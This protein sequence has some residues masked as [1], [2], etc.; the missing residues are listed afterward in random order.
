MEQRNSRR[1]SPGNTSR[2]RACNACTSFAHS[3]HL[4]QSERRTSDN[5]LSGRC[6][7]AA[8]SRDHPF[9]ASSPRTLSLDATGNQLI[10]LKIV[11][12]HTNPIILPA[13][14]SLS[15]TRGY[16]LG[17]TLPVAAKAIAMT[18]VESQTAMTLACQPAP[19]SKLFR[20]YDWGTRDGSYPI[21]LLLNKQRFR[22]KAVQLSSN[23]IKQTSVQSITMV[24]SDKARHCQLRDFRQRDNPLCIAEG[25]GAGELVGA[26]S[27]LKLD[28]S[29]HALK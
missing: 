27:N 11:Q 24:L 22:W 1:D 3:L 28:V 6:R 10:Q 8:L 13:S 2:K 17:T 21:P 23:I 7:T 15:K 16:M 29:L 4:S 26:F 18:V 25:V 12:F 20:N 14:Y 5:I 19:Q 9:F